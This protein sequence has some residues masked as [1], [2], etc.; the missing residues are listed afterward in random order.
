MGL[1][2]VILVQRF[3]KSPLI[4]LQFLFYLPEW[5]ERKDVHYHAFCTLLIVSEVIVKILSIKLTMTFTALWP[6]HWLTL[7][8][9][10]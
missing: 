3:R 6:Q 9:Y 2:A 8:E 4:D 10:F 1:V 5:T 7:S